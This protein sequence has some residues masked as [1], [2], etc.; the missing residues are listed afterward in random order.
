MTMSDPSSPPISGSPTSL[1]WALDIPVRYVTV[2]GARI[3]YLVAGS[4][5]ALVL[6]H[7]LRTQL[8]MFQKVIP[9]LAMR[10]RVYAL[11]YP[12]HGHSDAPGADYAAQ[13]FVKFV[14]G[15]LDRLNIED[16]VL[17]GESIEGTI[18]LLLAARRNP[19]VRGV[20][21]VNPYDYDR[22]RGLRRSS[23]LANVFIGMSGLPLIGGA[24]GRVQPYSAVKRILQGGRL[25]ERRASARAAARAPRRRNEAGPL[26]RVLAARASLAQLGGSAGRVRERR[27]AGAPALRRPRLVP[28]RRA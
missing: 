22:G 2:D 13:F 18:A 26:A 19:R 4:G 7:T 3:R 24:M 28:R 17:A 25:S 5:P 12:G 10:F 15:F 9:E 16:A 20:V 21:A 11:D 23:A 6:L 8:D 14:A 27:R 1:P